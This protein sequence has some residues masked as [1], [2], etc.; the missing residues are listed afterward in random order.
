[1]LL[2]YWWR[3]VQCYPRRL[4]EL[5]FYWKHR[6]VWLAGHGERV[7]K[8][9]LALEAAIRVAELL[10][11]GMLVQLGEVMLSGHRYRRLS[12]QEAAFAKTYFTDLE[13]KHAVVDEGSSRLARP[14]GVAFVLGYATKLWGTPSLPLLMHELVHVRQFRRWGWAYVA[15][16]LAAQHLGEG[17]TYAKAIAHPQVV[18]GEQRENL[19]LRESLGAHHSLNA[20][21]EAARLEDHVRVM[22]SLPPRWVR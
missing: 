12:M 11:V 3:F 5:V 2:A 1:M 6:E 22:L 4:G 9:G 13:L 17:Y 15:K 16:A 21:Q 7:H 10:G 19:S 14:L 20:E 18:R 8:R